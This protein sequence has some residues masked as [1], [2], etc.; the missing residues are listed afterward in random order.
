MVLD[1]IKNYG[2]YANI[3]ERLAAGFNFINTSDLLAIAVGTYEIDGKAIFAIV[4]EYDTKDE[5]DCFLEGHTKYIDIQYMVQGTEMMGITTKGNQKIQSFDVDKD[6]TFYEGETSYIKVGAGMFTLFFPDD[7]HR[8][9]I[10]VGDV[11]KV[12]KVVV[13]VQI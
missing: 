12:K 8:P 2:L 1:S 6:Y 5:K 3:T 4:Q 9:C 11:T 13:K 10:R 7:L